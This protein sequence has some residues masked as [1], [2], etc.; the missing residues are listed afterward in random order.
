[1]GVRGQ[2]DSCFSPNSS[3]I[4]P[5]RALS[6]G[7]WRAAGSIQRLADAISA[8]AEPVERVTPARPEKN[9]TEG[10]TKKRKPG[11]S[12]R[13]SREIIALRRRRRCYYTNRIPLHEFQPHATTISPY[14]LV[15]YLSYPSRN[16]DRRKLHRG[17]F[18]GPAGPLE[19]RR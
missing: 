5:G 3:G 4:S 11:P 7:R 19:T 14:L 13:R 1:M 16:F 15:L 10:K 18:L 17:I 8:A 6:S 12:G 2:R 9:G